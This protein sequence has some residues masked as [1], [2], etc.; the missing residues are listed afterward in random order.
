VESRLVKSWHQ[1]ALQLLPPQLV[2]LPLMVA[3]VSSPS[4]TY[5]LAMD[6]Y[7][8]AINALRTKQLEPA[9]TLATLRRLPFP[10]SKS[11]IA[12]PVAP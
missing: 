8:F 11:W 2:R 5:L 7:P 4:V 10:S 12:A 6:Q 3:T 1:I 9:P